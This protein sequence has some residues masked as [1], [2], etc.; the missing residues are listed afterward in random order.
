MG[1]SVLK[2]ALAY[3][4]MIFALGFAL[5]TVRVLWLTPR[6]GETAAVLVE[7]PFM[8]AA[9]AL[10][11]HRLVRRHA[12]GGAGPA[13]AMGA[14]ALALLMAAEAALALGLSGQGLAGWAR[15]LVA[16]PGVLGLA[17]QLAFAAMPLLV[18]AG[19]AAG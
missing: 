4:A 1:R 18:V 15:A 16:M 7:L 8:L 3:W 19:R 6:F 5:G 10:A 11:A 14:L 12:V 17:G 9:S 2:A 13:L